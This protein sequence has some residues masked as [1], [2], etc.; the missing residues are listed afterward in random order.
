MK[1]LAK[2]RRQEAKT[3]YYKRKR[4]LEGE[5]PR[6]VIRK[7]NRYIIIQYTESKLAQDKVVIGLS[8]KELLENGWPKES[9]GSLKSLAGAYLAGYLFGTKAKK[10]D[11]AILD[12]GLI[13]NTK[14]SRIYAALKGMVD[15]GFKIAHNKDIFPSEERIKSENVEAFFDKVKDKI[16]GAKK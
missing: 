6:V 3:N 9:A 14:G 15:A 4:L 7:T 16:Q 10:L 11:E 1:I 8:S 2:R 5:K 12:M 13:R